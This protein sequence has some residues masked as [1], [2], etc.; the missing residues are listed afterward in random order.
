MEQNIDNLKIVRTSF[1]PAERELVVFLMKHFSQDTP[2]SLI[3]FLVAKEA[4]EVKDT[5][6]KY[7]SVDR[8]ETQ[9]EKA[10]RLKGMSDEELT[11]LLYE[12]GFFQDGPMK[13][14]PDCTLSYSIGLD[15]TGNVSGR[16]E[17][18]KY[19]QKDPQFPP[20]VN[21]GRSLDEIINDVI[22]AK[23]I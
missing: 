8:K 22:K 12:V 15:Q 13:G 2:Q 10:L 23:L 20:Y 3:R 4:Q 1:K 19:T 16:V 7:G 21:V 5:Q 6:L 18:V 14:A 17:L 9:A 11:K